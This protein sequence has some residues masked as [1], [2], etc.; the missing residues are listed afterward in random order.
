MLH[1]R[2]KV[3]SPLV[4]IGFWRTQLNL[5]QVPLPPQDSTHF[6][7]VLAILIWTRVIQGTGMRSPC[8][9]TTRKVLYLA[10]LFLSAS[11][12]P[13]GASILGSAQNFAVLVWCVTQIEPYRESVG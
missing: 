3:E 11:S 12:L 8:L 4:D 2:F 13:L 5:T 10:I 9:K 6:T 7:L 1:T